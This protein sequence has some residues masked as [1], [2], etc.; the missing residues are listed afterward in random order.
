[1]DRFPYT[2]KDLEQHFGGKTMTPDEEAT[3]AN[4][5]QANNFLRAA[6]FAMERAAATNSEIDLSRTLER[7]N[8]MKEDVIAIE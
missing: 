6:I 4:L 5:I 1:M 3:I 2:N 8:D 7:L